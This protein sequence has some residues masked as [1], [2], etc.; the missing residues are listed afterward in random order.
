MKISA[1]G[2]AIGARQ[3]WFPYEAAILSA[4]QIADEY[5]IAYDARFDNPQTFTALSGKVKPL[6]MDID[7]MEW[8]FLCTALTKARRACDGD[9]LLFSEL[10]EVYHEKDTTRIRQRT[11]EAAASNTSVGINYVVMCGDAVIPKHFEH[12]IYRQK[13]TPNEPWLYHKVSDHMIGHIE[14]DVWEGKYILTGFDDVSYHDERIGGWFF[15]HEG[16]VM[17]DYL[18]PFEGTKKEE[19]EY[20]TRKMAYVW[21]YCNFNHGRKLEQGRQTGPWLNREAGITGAFDHDALVQ[22]LKEGIVWPCQTAR[23]GYEYF[24]SQGWIPCRLSHPAIA[25]KWLWEMDWR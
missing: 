25:T 6:E 19:I 13:L 16:L 4:L 8:D 22:G 23:E 11:E 5:V 9:Y 24:L 18:E 1:Y 3:R 15:D 10:D 17:D 7:F 14:S 21:H 12:L 20:K 2:V